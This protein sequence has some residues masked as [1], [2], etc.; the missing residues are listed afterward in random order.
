MFVIAQMETEE[1]DSHPDYLVGLDN[2]IIKFKTKQEAYDFLYTLDIS[3]VD[4][5]QSTVQILRM[6]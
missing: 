1:K 6:Q 2:N 5:D 3:K 4:F